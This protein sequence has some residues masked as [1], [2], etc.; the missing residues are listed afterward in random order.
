MIRTKRT[1][2]DE[3]VAEY[4]EDLDR[5]LGSLPYARRRELAHDLE[6]HVA[7]ARAALDDPHDERAVLVILARL[8]TPEEIAAEARSGVVADDGPTWREPAAL[9]L[10]LFGGFLGGVGWLAG[11]ALLWWSPLWTVREK[12]LGT[13]VIPG[14][15]ALGLTLTMSG[16]VGGYASCDSPGCQDGPSIIGILGAAFVV[17]GPLLVTGLLALR[18]RDRI[19]V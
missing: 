6:A 15:L 1:P 5:A 17:L 4:A 2:A 10:L 16:I 12:L 13:L 11:V 9:V 19:Y 3:L 18:R 8:G 14:G 7:E